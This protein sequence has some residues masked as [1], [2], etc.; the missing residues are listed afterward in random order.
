[1]MTDRVTWLSEE[2][3]KKCLR[4]FPEMHRRK[5]GALMAQFFHDRLR[6]VRAQNYPLGLVSLWMH[7]LT[8]VA[9]NSVREQIY[10]WRQ[11]RMETK[12]KFEF[13]VRYHVAELVCGGLAVTIS[14][15][16][17]RYGMT[18]LMITTASSTVIAT[19]VAT[20]LDKRWRRMA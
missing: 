6:E 18:A 17:F 10:E 20:L 19:I 11:N 1:M 8:D 9:I 13:L 7:T 15:L 16:S 4:F 5:Y 2:I 14:F 3:Y 12:S